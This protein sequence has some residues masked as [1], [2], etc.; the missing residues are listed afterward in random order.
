MGLYTQFLRNRQR[1][2]GAPNNGFGPH[3][4]RN[5]VPT[6]DPP[7]G[8][9]QLVRYWERTQ[10]VAWPVDGRGR[11]QIEIPVRAFV[12]AIHGLEMPRDYGGKSVEELRTWFRAA[13]DVWSR[14]LAGR[15]AD[16]AQYGRT[17]LAPVDR[18][19]D[20][21]EAAWKAWER[22]TVRRMREAMDRERASH[23]EFESM[24]CDVEVIEIVSLDDGND[25]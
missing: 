3:Y 23:R 18:Y 13:Q 21:C 12:Y 11:V 6:Y 24:L 22:E 10:R 7:M 16:I 4:R 5:N 8:Y 1:E 19:C 2:V 14:W 25:E 15:E 17:F 20:R 9:W